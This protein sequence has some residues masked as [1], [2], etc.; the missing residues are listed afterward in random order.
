MKL[1]SLKGGI[2]PED[3]K[4]AE[5]GV[6]R[7]PRILEGDEFFIPF[8]QHIGAPAEC[9]VV[10][11]QR[12]R[13][14]E[15]LAK[16]VSGISAPVHSPADG[17]ITAIVKVP[18][19]VLGAAEGCILKA[20]GLEDGYMELEDKGDLAEMV[21]AAGVVGLGGAG[22]PAW[23][24]IGGVRRADTLLINASECEPYLT[25]DYSL[26]LNYP[27]E[28]L[29]GVKFL[30]DYINAQDAFIAVESNK[31]K[32]AAIL[33]GLAPSYGAEVV[34]VPAKYPQGGEKQLIS[35]VLSRTVPQ[36]RLPI[37]IGV[38]IHN[39]ATVRAIYEAVEKRKPLFERPLTVSG[40]VENPCNIMA[41][42]GMT[43]AVL[44]RETQNLYDGG[45]R[46]IF[47]GPMT[48]FEV[49]GPEMPVLK[50]T[51]GILQL[52]RAEEKEPGPCIRCGRCVEACV[53]GLVPVD[54]ER[55]YSA[56]N[57]NMM[58]EL[59]AASCIEC[60]CCS[61][62]CPA[63]RPLAQAIKTGKKRAAFAAAKRRGG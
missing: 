19:P 58:I 33:S 26:M 28:I 4:Y 61:Y 53:M 56:G 40:L 52:E 29:K 60:G 57:I 49:T 14:G 3:N 55:A 32:A 39:V 43:A 27:E 18:H 10:K 34:V 23:V 47:G 59:N 9:A 7:R 31:K 35:T 46:L 37:D 15:R 36:G 30:K 42:T 6:I 54:L 45:K 63:G 51:G 25:C 50:T 1:S 12:V 41:R 48:G 16:A 21:K 38:L 5:A 8:S 17:I 2:H 44:F 22:F 11:G 24:K 20:S 13:T 62:V